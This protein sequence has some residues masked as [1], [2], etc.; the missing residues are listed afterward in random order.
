MVER[1]KASPGGALLA[2]AASIPAHCA[3]GVEASRLTVSGGVT[4]I[5]AHADDARID[6][7]ATASVD[8][9]LSYPG[10]RG[11]WFT[12]IEGNTSLQSD[13]VATV[14]IEANADAGTALDPD[15]GGRVQVSEVNYRLQTTH[16]ARLTA[17]LIDPSSYLD[18]TRITNDENVQFLGV[19]FVNN[20][21][22]EFPDY[23][24]GLAYERP[25][26]RARPQLNAVLA[27]SNGLADNPNV[28]YSQL[29]QVGG[30]DKGVFAG[31]G[32]G[33][34]SERQLVRVGGWLNTRSHA[35]LSGD[36]DDESNFGVY[37][38]YGRSWGAHAINMRAGAA[39]GE[40]S[41]AAGFAS[42]AY[43]YHWHGHALG[44]GLAQTFLS[45]DDREAAADD[46][47]QLELFGRFAIAARAHLTASLQ[48]LRHSGFVADA[49]DPRDHAAV[50]G[51]RFHY[52]F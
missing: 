50:G 30:T 10:E 44:V 20:P 39:N 8:L 31:L 49:A 1:R 48:W 27:S 51:L 41:R 47:T 18:R 52:G 12:Y 42:L 4:A 11:E 35:T 13:G 7:E 9:N 34:V 16:G 36:A 19:G 46:T 25:G 45:G 5:L 43:R 37:G 33:W 22:I 24:L 32:L 2:L 23:T 17:G 21:T 3:A 6:D 15:R 26:A 38:V 14:L 40:V 28:S 29:L